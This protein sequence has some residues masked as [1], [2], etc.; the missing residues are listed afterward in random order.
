[1]LQICLKAVMEV[2]IPEEV[3]TLHY[4]RLQGKRSRFGFR[5]Q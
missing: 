1:M 5:L 4:V 3:L 2:W